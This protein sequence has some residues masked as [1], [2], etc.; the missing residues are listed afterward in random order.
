MSMATLARRLKSAAVPPVPPPKPLGGTEKRLINQRG[1]TGSTG[2]TEKNNKAEESRGP[3][4]PVPTPGGELAPG[5]AATV[6]A[7]LDAIGETDPATRAE[8]LAVCTGNPRAL[9]WT[10]AELAA[11][12]ANDPKPEVPTQA[13]ERPSVHCGDCRHFVASYTSP[14]AG[15]GACRIGTPANRRSPTHRCLDWRPGTTR[16]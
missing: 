13:E 1:T 4:A 11:I 14:T 3:R 5:D 2:S 9:A 15:F 16:M 8:Y 12:R 6:A 7:W 10:R